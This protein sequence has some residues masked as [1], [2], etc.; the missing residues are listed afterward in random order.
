ME[1][2]AFFPVQTPGGIMGEKKATTTEPTNES[3]EHA[4]ERETGVKQNEIK[5]NKTHSHSHT[6]RII[7]WCAHLKLHVPGLFELERKALRKN[8]LCVAWFPLA[9]PCHGLAW[10]I[11]AMLYFTLFQFDFVLFC[12]VLSFV[13]VSSNI[14][15]KINP[16]S[17]F[18][19][20]S[21]HLLLW[22]IKHKQQQQLNS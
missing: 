18:Y 19:T 12:F 22:F 16:S 6:Q 11:S 15:L 10:L 21:K 1:S 8:M 20:F 17:L 2:V 4:K 7:K 5:Q 13:P 3:A 14:F 9:L